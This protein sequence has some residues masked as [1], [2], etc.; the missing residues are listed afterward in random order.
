MKRVIKTAENTLEEIEN[1]Y[2]EAYSQKGPD[3]S[4]GTPARERHN[5]APNISVNDNNMSASNLKN[6]REELAKKKRDKN[7]QTLFR[8][9]PSESL[10]KRM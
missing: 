8:L 6:A 9:P 1:K 5:S 7:F 10:L 3:A 2:K 4:P